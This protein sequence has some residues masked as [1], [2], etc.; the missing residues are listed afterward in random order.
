MAE[1][2][3]TPAA[4]DTS[5]A[6]PKRITAVDVQQKQFRLAFRGYHEREVD[7]FLDQVTEEL[8]RL[9]A[10]NRRLQEEIGLGPTVHR[11]GLGDADQARRA[12]EEAE[13][14][15]Q[16]AEARAA[17]LLGAAESRAAGL[18]E[19]ARSARELA[20]SS[21]ESGRG[22]GDDRLSRLLS[23]E[24]EFLQSLA[25]LV[26]EHMR[27]VKEEA[28]A[29]R[30]TVA[31]AEAISPPAPAWTGLAG[32][33][34]ESESVVEPEP[35]EPIAGVASE[36]LEPV[37]RLAAEPVEEIPTVAAPEP[38]HPGP[39]AAPPLEESPTMDQPLAPSAWESLAR[40]REEEAPEPAWQAT[41]GPEIEP[42][43]LGEIRVPEPESPPELEPAWG[44][45]TGEIQ[46]DTPRPW[47]AQ[48]EGAADLERED[49]AEQPPMSPSPSWSA[50][51]D[52]GGPGSRPAWPASSA[53]PEPESDLERPEEETL[54]RQ[55]TLPGDE[56]PAND[57]GRGYRNA[58]DS[59]P[60]SDRRMMGSFGDED[61]G[62]EDRSLRELFWGEES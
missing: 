31:P 14:L 9:Q 62:D 22:A 53:E 42:E 13:R 44:G 33:A 20:S 61:A 30:E 55:P 45:T 17:A 34:D 56:P 48:G 51:D 2:E 38:Y 49:E 40:S 18:L 4:P 50:P 28:R 16:D 11:G 32:T 26:Q 41:V 19:E 12:Q 43:D 59:D 7:E 1:N 52:S 27:T 21:S 35:L 10:E 8:A 5:D 3:T 54:F 60:G 37:P 25:G 47:H 39:E 58:S 57:P 24:R 15:I 23:Q 29:A 46:P 36:P 6:T